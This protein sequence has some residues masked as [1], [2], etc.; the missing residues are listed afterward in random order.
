M[1]NWLGNSLVT[2]YLSNVDYPILKRSID[3][4]VDSV[5][6]WLN[7]LS[8]RECILGGRIEFIG[9]INPITDLI[10]GIVKFKIS[11]APPSPMR[12]I[13]FI[14]EYDPDYLSELF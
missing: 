3:S 8:S 10:D 6:M 2:N 14:I 5:G 11:F 1:F 7:S 13:E 12:D 9:D 4:I